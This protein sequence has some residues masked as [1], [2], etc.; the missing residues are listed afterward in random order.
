MREKCQ[1]DIVKKREYVHVFIGG[2]ESVSVSGTSTNHFPL[3]FHSIVFQR[4]CLNERVIKINKIKQKRGRYTTFNTHSPTC[5]SSLM[6]RTSTPRCLAAIKHDEISLQVM[7]NTQT[8]WGERS[9]SKISK[10]WEKEQE[11]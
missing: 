8:S 11:R 10:R 7:V 9:D 2:D 5:S 4:F 6:T 3:L 1:K